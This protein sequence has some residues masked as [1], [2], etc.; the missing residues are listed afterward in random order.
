VRRWLLLGAVGLVAATGGWLLWPEVPSPRPPPEVDGPR[1]AE[2]P[3]DRRVAEP[4]ARAPEQA[5]VASALRALESPSA[6]RQAGDLPQDLADRAGPPPGVDAGDAGPD[7]A[8]AGLPD[9]ALEPGDAGPVIAEPTVLDAGPRLVDDASP[10][11]VRWGAEG[12]CG[13]RRGE[14]LRATR[15]ALL[16][17]FVARTLGEAQLLSDP[18]IDGATL[19]LVAE[20][21]QVARTATAA[22]MDWPSNVPPPVTV[23]YADTAQLQS[24]GCVSAQTIG[25]F[26]GRIHLSA[27]PAL[28]P[29]VLGETVLH[30][31]VHFALVNS[32]VEKPMWLH[33]G[34]ATRVAEEAWFVSGPID[35]ARWLRTSHLPFS[36]MVYVFPHVAEE[37][38][39][40][41]ATYQSTRMVDFLVA[42]RGPQA[43]RELVRLLVARAV[44]PDEA[45]TRG[46]GLSPG[47][48]DP[49]WKAFVAVP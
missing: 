8:D 3:P 43:V 20:R 39:A 14:D 45:F 42:R 30:E 1:A 40:L 19:S 27:D 15:D 44:T 31:Y 7:P 6:E 34:L 49:Q 17:G 16:S 4:L 32:G 21:L 35:F 41:A 47:E 10:F 38:L 22:W 36:A 46:S 23:V 12:L 18:L 37:R 25:Y 2:P 24:V 26:D 11:R 9:G 13:T 48:L 33:E 29:R 28:G 5:D